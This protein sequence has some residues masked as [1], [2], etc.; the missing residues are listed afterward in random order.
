MRDDSACF[1]YGSLRFFLLEA[2]DAVVIEPPPI[3]PDEFR[4]EEAR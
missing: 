1:W 2:I 3:L 4:D